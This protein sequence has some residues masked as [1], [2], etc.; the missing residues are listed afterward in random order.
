MTPFALWLTG[1]FPQ[2]MIWVGIAMTV[3]WV[4]RGVVLALVQEPEPR[5]RAPLGARPVPIRR[6]R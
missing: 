3:L 2:V 4:V 1:W 5:Q 6:R